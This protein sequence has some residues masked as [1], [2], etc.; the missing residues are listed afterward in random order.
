MPQQT[1]P[2]NQN[3]LQRSQP[4]TPTKSHEHGATVSFTDKCAYG[5]EASTYTNIDTKETGSQ[6]TRDV[7]VQTTK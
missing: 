5:R 3:L 6:G 1:T 7:S 4:S 2:S